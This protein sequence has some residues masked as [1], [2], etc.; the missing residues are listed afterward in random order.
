MQYQ[1]TMRRL[2]LPHALRAAVA[3][4]LLALC[5]L[6]ADAGA[7]VAPIDRYRITATQTGVGLLT[8]QGL[9]GSVP[10]GARVTLTNMRTW[11]STPMVV[12]AADGS[13]STQISGLRGDGL[14]AMVS[15]QAGNTSAPTTFYADALVIKNPYK[16]GGHWH[17][18]QGHAHT[19]NSDGV[20]TPAYLEASY[21]LAGYDFVISTD[22]RGWPTPVFTAED[23]GM[24]PDPDTGGLHDLLWIRGA[25]IGNY[26][27]H[28][29]AWGTRANVPL[30]SIPATQT[31][32]DTVRALG[33]IAVINHPENTEPPHAW[34]WHTEIAPLRNVS[35]IEAYNGKHADEGSRENHL[36]D[37]MDL[38][39]EFQQV[40][41]IGTDDCHNA[42]DPA[43]FN[44][45]AMVV[46]TDSAA[47]SQ[48]DILAAADA[49]QLYIRESAQ[50]PVIQGVSVAGNTVELTLA[51]IASD[52]DV[53]WYKRGGEKVKT[54]TG[55][56]AA[57]AYVMNG[58]EG[59]I[60]A[61]VTRRSDGKHAYTQPLFVANN[62][63]LSAAASAAALVDN[64]STTVWDAGGATGS[65]VVDTGAL[66][67]LNAIR[68]D[69]DGAGGRRF[70]Y[71]V[72]VSDSG[73]FEGEERPV[74]RETFSNRLPRTVDFFD[75]WSRF[76]RVVI[77]GQSLGPAGN[78]RVRE[79]EVFD[80]SPAYTNLY[81]NNESGSDSQSGLAGLPWRSFD[82]AREHVRPRDALNFVQTLTPYPGGMQLYDRHSGKHP[83]AVVQYRGANG[84]PATVNAAGT[85]YGVTL[86]NTQWLQWSDFDMAG[87]DAANVLVLGGENNSVTRNRLHHGRGR[88]VL[89]GG[90]VNLAYNLIYG[91]A[92]D[93]VLVYRSGTN[94][95]V[96]NNVL[97]G[98]GAD[99]LAVQN[100]GP[101]SA[102]VR[103]N[104]TGGNGRYA[105]WRELNSTVTD[106]H[107]CGEGAY[108]GVWFRTG[109][110]S[111]NPRLRDPAAGD[112][113]LQADSP[114]I[115]AGVD[116][117]YNADFDGEPIR[118][119]LSVPD[120]GSPGAYSRTYTD[121]GAYEACDT[122]NG[123]GGCH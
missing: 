46:Q 87:A 75:A 110:V 9:P 47:I 55:V 49:G 58:S 10:A 102:E 53:D 68:I 4:V 96:F 81:I 119:M 50:G 74:V 11:A 118:D 116:L 3:P 25:E 67:A 83:A 31:A 120:K 113:T 29:G 71:R 63:D 106:S 1:Y 84:V 48:A 100:V 115:D 109:S 6:A 36:S 90:G 32:V 27:V 34:D 41:W 80:A 26:T 117:N 122:C 22:H 23:D 15:D 61:V 107:N 123:G 101:V 8:V 21:Y 114:C 76:V 86:D 98:N 17:V 20:N 66:R 56:N 85:A 79:V 16:A 38:A 78:A 51:D 44:R 14:S 70:N 73:L 94:A 35:L 37:A 82:F 95:K 65:F 62:R 54:N 52:Y 13:F 45:Y 99:G 89:A 59:Y 69:W 28:M 111:A 7:Q 92:G 64:N 72:E 5:L 104:V 12:P 19:T 30:N 77:T 2:P 40:W 103:N 18:G 105:F 91:N 42:N 57:A 39:D 93:G 24:T 88:G 33:G 112:F 108:S 60:R 121:M 43:Q 97:Y